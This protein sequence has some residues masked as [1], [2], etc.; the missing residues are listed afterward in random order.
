M[1]HLLS[2]CLLLLTL[3][4]CAAAPAP[5]T[6]SISLQ[7]PFAYA[8]ELSHRHGVEILVG[9]KAAEVL[10]WDYDITPETD[11]Q[12]ILDALTQLDR[13]LQKYPAGM[14]RVLSQDAGGLHICIVR[15]I[16]GKEDTGSLDSAKGL[17][18]RDPSRG[19]FLML[20]KDRENTLY[21][22]LCHV[23]EDFVVPRSDAWKDWQSL[24]PEGFAYDMDFEKNRDRDGS[25]WLQEKTQAFVDTYS[26]SFPREDR[27]RIM[28]YA[29]AE[30][31]EDL[32]A[33]PVM[34]KKLLCLS[35]GIREAFSLT[36]PQMNLSW[37]Q[38]LKP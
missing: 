21:H 16:L 18:F 13:G 27:A 6:P 3:T 33:S 35:Q 1:K 15:E 5:E 30:G 10:P 11:N 25:P 17:Q 20:A 31:N 29:M 12:E 14:V 8:S 34:Q 9:E 26:M 19:T 23:L 7:D 38:Y 36:D 28:E 37:E 32:F 4:G 24:N 2:V 22:E